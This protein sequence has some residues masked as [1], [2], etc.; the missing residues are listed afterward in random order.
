M[1]V[2]IVAAVSAES[3]VAS[4]LRDQ[5]AHIIS[6][7]FFLVIGLIAFSIAA[8]RRRGGVRMLV[9]LGV[10][11]AMFGANELAGSPSIAAALPHHFRAAL[12]IFLV[13]MSYLMVVVGT[14][15]F[16]ELS[17]GGLRRVLQVFVAADLAIAIAGIILFLV[18]GRG[19]AL[20]LYNNLLAALTLAVLVAV[21]AVPRVSQRFLI[22][23]GHRALTTGTFIFA[24]Q[25]LHANLA[26]PLHYESPGIFS[27]LGFAVL[28]LSFGYTAVEIIVTNERRLL[29]IENELQIA[30]QL[31]F[32]ILPG[33]MPDVPN[34]RISVAYEPMTAV[35]GDFY[36]FLPAD[37]HRV[38]FLVAD[39][40]GHGVPAALIASMIK[41]AMQSV[42]PCAHDPG[43]V[44]CG[45]NRILARQLRGQFVS[46]AY[47]WLDTE[48]RRA[49]YSAAGH[50]PLL[51]W[52]QGKL[53]R[54]E[55]NGLLF[56]VIEEYD[57]Y[58]V[59]AIPIAAGD[60][61][62]LCTDGVTEPENASGDSFGDA[63]LEEVVRENQSRTPSE[64]LSQVLSAL[65][66]WQ[67]ASVTQQD[68][69]TLIV[70]DVV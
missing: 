67:P 47:L 69:I 63:R 37:E 16:L 21:V 24:A 64:L 35:A 31:Q 32:S 65:R 45:L 39:V 51:R 13:V 11:S 25:A 62:L 3:E 10:W 42:V 60:R 40:S 9:W 36:D 1:A 17:L 59:C 22:V 33:A 15:S 26:R 61:F 2:S 68:D 19:D 48:N 7:T 34:L 41:V 50:P 23:A 70:I 30:R 18:S 20:I 54:I 53:E 46:A 55:S 28:L 57:D 38:G 29:S 8:I 27:S 52:C 58:P 4:L 12:P 43:A 56:G 5:L 6:G 49:L 66:K 14:L 44:L